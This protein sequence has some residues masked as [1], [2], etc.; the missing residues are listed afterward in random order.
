[1][2]QSLEANPKSV[3][4]RAELARRYLRQRDTS[5]VLRLTTGLSE[6]DYSAEPD[7]LESQGKAQAIDGDL[8]AAQRSFEL[9]TKLVPESPEAHF[10]LGDTLARNGQQ[11]RA[12]EQ[13]KEAIE[14][15]PNYLLARIGEIRM[16][17]HAGAI[18]EAERAL[19]DLIR[20]FPD[21]PDALGI[22]GWFA[23]GKRDYATAADRLS[24]AMAEKPTSDAVALLARALWMQQKRED[25]IE[26][27][28]KWLE[29]N[30]EDILVMS[31][32][33]EAYTS[34]NMTDN[35]IDIYA[36]ILERFP[37]DFASLNNLAW[38]TQDRDFEEAISFAAK[39]HAIAPNDPYVLD[40]YGTLLLKKGNLQRGSRLIE[41]AAQRAPGN[42]E[43]Q[44]NFGRILVR[45]QRYA[46]ARQIV[47][48]V[49]EKSK[50]EKTTEQAK[51][52][53]ATIQAN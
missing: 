5:S 24:A 17:T 51:A 22:Q 23:L 2:E 12:R 30:P 8:P 13:L 7:L 46:D 41:Q 20:D 49:L 26:V 45:Q 14:L 9:W 44:L 29:R 16:L 32:L 33:A 34:S 48:T 27:M 25:A 10:F 28:E 35:A 3:T 43:I 53:L 18:E 47:A 50:D 36:S 52:L 39:A 19:E 1:L 11:E 21:D 4:V 38:L 42:L 40:T 6:D 31:Q 37:N 15:D